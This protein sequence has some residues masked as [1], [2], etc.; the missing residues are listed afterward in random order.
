MHSEDNMH[1]ATQEAV[2]SSLNDGPIM[3]RAAQ[4]TS[5]SALGMH[6]HMSSERLLYIQ[7][8]AE[9]TPSK[10]NQKLR[11]DAAGVKTKHRRLPDTP[12]IIQSQ[13]QKHRDDSLRS[14]LLNTCISSDEF[15]L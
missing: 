3:H 4:N 1:S 6:R 15:P 10:L 12:G 9:V 14:Y 5:R 13:L 8:S 2:M 7:L 11:L